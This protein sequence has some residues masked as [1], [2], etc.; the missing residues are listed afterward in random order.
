MFRS[1][2]SV[3]YRMGKSRAGKKLKK[4]TRLL[5][6]VGAVL[7]VLLLTVIWG[8]IW[9]EKAQESALRRAALR[10]E[11]KALAANTPASSGVRCAE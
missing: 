10:E 6:V 7:L 11:E 5:F 3:S 4:Y 2:S 9:G 8:T 1:R